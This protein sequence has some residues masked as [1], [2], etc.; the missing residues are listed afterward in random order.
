MSQS[1]CAGYFRIDSDQGP[2]LLVRGDW[3]VAKLRTRPL[4]AAFSFYRQPAG[5]LFGIFVE[6]ECPE[7]SQAS[8]TGH[9]VFE[10]IYGMDFQET[11]ERARQALAR[12]AIHLCFADAATNLNVEWMQPDGTFRKMSA[13][14]CRFERICPV[15]EDCRQIL[16][17]EY[18]QLLAYHEG[19]S[20]RTR[21]YQRSIRELSAD[22]PPSAY[23]ILE[24][25]KAAP[26]LQRIPLLGDNCDA[27]C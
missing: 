20:P 6:A 14:C 4:K 11:V 9:A 17:R 24:R 12:D 21:N 1:W 23:P 7:L 10:C 22:F 15:D 13:P 19:V 8:P 3:H 16:M 27:L 5:A 18:Q 25:C 2:F 26:A